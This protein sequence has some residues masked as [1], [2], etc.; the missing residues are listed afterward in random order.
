MSDYGDLAIRSR[1]VMAH[2]Q[3]IP[4]RT[5]AIALPSRPRP[6]VAVVDFNNCN[7]PT[8]ILRVRNRGN[9]QCENQCHAGDKQ[10]AP[11]VTVFITIQYLPYWCKQLE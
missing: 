4:L 11:T 5:V 7:R 6:I 3:S 1:R 2:A 9:H 10:S 8:S